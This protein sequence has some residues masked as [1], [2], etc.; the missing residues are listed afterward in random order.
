MKKTVYAAFIFAALGMTACGEQEGETSNEEGTEKEEK[1]EEV[2]SESYKL[3]AG[4]SML[5]WR[6]AWVMQTEDGGKEEAKHHTGTIDVTEGNVSVEGE[7]VEGTFTIDLTSINVTDLDGDEKQGLESHL[8]GTNEEKEADDFFNTDEYMNASV[9]L[10]SFKDGVADLT[11]S[12]I[13]VELNEQVEVETSMKDG[14]MM[15]HGEFNIDLATL[16]MAM[17]E[18]DPE[19]GNIDTSIGFKLHL[20]M[21]KE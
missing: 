1:Q 11:I 12:V 8:K 16:D 5:E 9:V 13:G 4:E 6:A 20:V 7:D 17:T 19:N 10:N 14:K 21:D 2:V 3:N 15:M 18:T